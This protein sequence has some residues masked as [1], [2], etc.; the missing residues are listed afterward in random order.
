MPSFAD[1]LL[2]FKYSASEK[3]VHGLALGLPWVTKVSFDL[4]QVFAKSA[5]VQPAGPPLFICGL[6]RAG[7]T[8]LME[9]FF[10][11][12]HYRSL[13]YSDMPFVLMPSV[14]RHVT[15]ALRTKGEVRERAHGDGLTIS[16]DSPEAFEEVFWRTFAGDQYIFQDRLVPH[17]A[18]HS[19]VEKFKLYVDQILKSAADNG[20][21]W[22]YL[23][24]N[25]NNIL[26]LEAI[27][28]AFPQALILIPFRDPIQHSMSL[29]RQHRR[30]CYIH[31]RDRFV[32]RY[33]SWLGHFEFGLCH[34]P[35]RFE[36]GEDEG[37]RMGT[38]GEINY[39]LRLWISTHRYLLN[40][41]PENSLFTCYEEFCENSRSSL[42]KLFELAKLERRPEQREIV[43]K[44]PLFRTA[45]T[46]DSN[47]L[48]EARSIYDEM[49][50]RT[51]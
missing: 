6:A 23:S 21:R 29:I 48:E 44:A 11:T 42:D 20:E 28:S 24:K 19:L 1:E 49:R 3:F 17:D 47:L 32:Y 25:N 22:R 50:R 9:A 5:P 14:W 2:E 13:T 31:K 8:A 18:D 38:P 26:R 45:P 40:R 12:G 30:F 33:M 51:L 46:M 35:F 39:W 37:I 15:Q 7:T 4:D 36:D 27:L 10:Q 16:Y 43:F 34:R 41:T